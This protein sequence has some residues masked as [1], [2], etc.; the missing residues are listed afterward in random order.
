MSEEKNIPEEKPES[1]NSKP[2]DT[3]ANPL[4]Q[5]KVE[6]NISPAPSPLPEEE[7]NETQTTEISTL[8]PPLQTSIMEVHH[9]GHVHEKKKWKEYLFQFLMLFLAVFCGFLA[10]YQLEHVIENSREKQF[11]ESMVADLE[12]DVVLLENE[13]KIVTQQYKKLDSLTEII[14]GGNLNEVNVRSMY[15]LQ[16]MYLS[17]QQLRL[18]NRTELQLKNAGGMRLIRNR[19]VTDSLIN[20]WTLSELLYETRYQINLHRDKAKDISFAIFNNKYY[21]HKVGFNLGNP[22]D[23]IMGEPELMTKDPNVLNEFANR[24][25]HMADLLKFNYTQRRIDRQRGNAKRLIE[26]IKKDYKL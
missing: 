24:V 19:Q 25:S 17:P 22:L 13:S 11:M 4:P 1:I 23:P 16:R 8:N 15:E 26:L 3:S 21:H 7:K 10:E 6:P 5:G 14:Y 2:S 18:I 20:Y 12:K 9:H